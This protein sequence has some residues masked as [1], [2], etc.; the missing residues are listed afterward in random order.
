LVGFID[1]SNVDPVLPII[2][3]VALT[4]QIALLIFDET[5]V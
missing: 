5:N 2:A 3:L 4:L 1:V